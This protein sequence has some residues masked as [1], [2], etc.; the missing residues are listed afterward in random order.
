MSSSEYE[1]AVIKTNPDGTREAVVLA[2]E[3]EHTVG[4]RRAASSLNIDLGAPFLYKI[5]RDTKR[6]DAPPG[7]RYDLIVSHD[8]IREWAEGL[9]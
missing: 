6:K 9:F 5:M 1:I 4:V 3:P 8:G 7:F 2:D